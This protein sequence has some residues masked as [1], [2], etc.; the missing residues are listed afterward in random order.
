MAGD[1]LPRRIVPDAAP[2]PAPTSPV[3]VSFSA[4][5]KARI[6]L[7]EESRGASPPA[8][9][10]EEMT[11]R[12]IDDARGDARSAGPSR[13]LVISY[14]DGKPH[15]SVNHIFQNRQPVVDERKQKLFMSDPK[16]R[17]MII[18]AEE[19]AAELEAMAA[20]PD[21]EADAII[22]RIMEAEDSEE[23]EAGGDDE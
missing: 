18:Q 4:T 13:K 7:N 5:L 9:F 2:T 6:M 14:T 11:D 17:E 16:L 12:I 23:R 20:R 19:R 1:N 15:Q 3:R 10:M 21:A 8:N 22:A